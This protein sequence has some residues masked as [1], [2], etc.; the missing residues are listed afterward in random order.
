LLLLFSLLL[1]SLLLAFVYW[2]ARRPRGGYRWAAISAFLGGVGSLICCVAPVAA[3]TGLFTSAVFLVAMLGKSSPGR[4]IAVCFVA[5]LVFHGGFITIN[6]WEYRDMARLYPVESLASRLAN[7][8]TFVDQRRSKDQARNEKLLKE[9]DASNDNMEWRFK[10]RSI[11][12]RRLH[13]ST[14]MDFVNSPGFGVSRMIFEP[15]KRRL[16]L[17][18]AEA[19]PF[20]EPWS[21]AKNDGVA[22]PRKPSQT[23]QPESKKLNDLLR[24]SIFDFV[25]PA[26]F[27][28]VLDR[29]HVRG[30]QPHHFHAFP[31]TGTTWQVQSVDLVSLL[32][33]DPPAVYV[34]SNLPR[35]QDLAGAPTRPLD[36]FEQRAL[37]R[38]F[39][40]KEL[41][42]QL[43]E[44]ILRM[45]GPIRAF[46]Q[47]LSCH[48][49]E[50][51][52]LLGAFSYRLEPREQ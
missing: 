31:E 44:T 16:K 46:K 51:G 35:M 11:M 28:Y 8:K 9:L 48:E 24:E 36:A 4:L 41:E 34:T 6:L 45:M 19:L 1:S 14:V 25:N 50:H 23:S 52:D 43:G 37:S 7:E 2:E 22:P 20:A 15:N 10:S 21:V 18:E 27:G 40:G 26:G 39:E 33:H 38:I 3:F 42:S 49:V 47:C 12:L 29:E 30:F 17:D 32:K 13:E 5:T